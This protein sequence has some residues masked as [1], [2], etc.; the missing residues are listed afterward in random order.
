MHRREVIAGLASAGVV[1]GGGALAVYGVPSV[2]ELTGEGNDVPD[3]LEIETIDAPGSE[4]GEVLVPAPDRATFVDIFGTWCPP[5]VEQMPE[6]AEANDRIGDEV[7]FI[8]VTNESVGETGSIT[9]DELVDWW[10]THGGDWTLGLDPTAELTERYLA[11]G[12]PTA[13][14]IDAAGRV[15][16]SDDGRKSAD[17]LV[18]GIEQAL[19]A[20]DG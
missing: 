4:A 20:E 5:C 17:E 6:L 7:L 11:G 8:S 16:W 9:E 14:S 3:P 1:A 18:A 15:Q 10:D 12:Y 13:V 19:E 2:E